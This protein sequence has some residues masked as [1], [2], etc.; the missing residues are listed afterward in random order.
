MFRASLHSQ[1]REQGVVVGG[2]CRGTASRGA[3]DADALRAKADESGLPHPS[4]CPSMSVA[5]LKDALRE[6]LERRG[7][8]DQL[9]ANVRAEVFSA[10]EDTEDPPPE[11]SSEN[12]VINELIR[13]YLAF[14]NYKHTLAVF[15]PEVGLPAEPLRRQYVAHQTRLPLNIGNRRGADLPLLYALTAKPSDPTPA[16]AA[17]AASHQQQPEQLE[18]PPAA[19]PVLPQHLSQQQQQPSRAPNYAALPATAQ[20]MADASAQRQRQQ[21]H[22]PTPVMF[23]MPP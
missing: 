11:M 6:A 13:D 3:R 4:A 15:S 1:A 17:W 10:M 23:T 20:L 7:V 16:P 5:D 18:P 9:R 14:N 2:A 19:A 21:H 22:G 12:L 8:L